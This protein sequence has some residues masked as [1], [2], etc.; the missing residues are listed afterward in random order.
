[1]RRR[2]FF[3]ILVLSF[4]CSSK[5][6]QDFPKIHKASEGNTVE[7][8]GR[9]TEAAW[10]KAN[11]TQITVREDWTIDISYFQDDQNL[12]FAFSNLK[13]NDSTEIYPEVL[14]DTKNDKSLTWD[15]NDWWFHTSYSNCENQAKFNDYSTCEIG[16]KEGWIGNNFPLE[17]GQSV[18]IKIEKKLLDLSEGDLIGIA[19]DVTDTQKE[20]FFSRPEAKLEEPATWMTI[21]I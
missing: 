3:I 13:L 14:I 19:F 12:Y 7:I 5:P 20:W 1:M 17:I 2:V 18:E 15:E 11:S 21:K 16:Q 6:K 10:Q 4:G 8:D 9:L